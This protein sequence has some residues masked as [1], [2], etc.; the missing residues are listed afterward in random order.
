MINFDILSMKC[1][2]LQTGKSPTSE[3]TLSK[4]D[5][6]KVVFLKQYDRKVGCCTVSIRRAEVT[7]H[8]SAM[9]QIHS[10]ILCLNGSDICHKLYGTGVD[11]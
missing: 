6:T 10:V 2:N 9:P 3:V 4:V 5:V 7:C 1:N 8:S 11:I